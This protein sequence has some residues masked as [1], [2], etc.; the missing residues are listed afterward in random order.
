MRISSSNQQYYIPQ[1]QKQNQTASELQA[2]D[3][4][5]ISLA[6]SL[7]SVAAYS[8]DSD[9]SSSV[10]NI[11]SDMLND[12]KVQM[13]KQRIN[14]MRES[15]SNKIE[16]IKTT[17]DTV[18][19]ADLENMSLEDKQA[20][21]ASVDSALS[22][23]DASISEI[24]ALS[25]DE[26]TQILTDIQSQAQQMVRGPSGPSGPGG[27]GGPGRLGGPC[28]PGDVSSVEEDDE[29]KSTLQTLLD[30]LYAAD[31]DEEDTTTTSASNFLQNYAINQY[32]NASSTRMSSLLDVSE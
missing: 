6:N 24:E 1:T 8:S 17:M 5:S 25:E 21:L 15:E 19:E 2:Y 30:A 14:S 22:G 3:A 31:E 16:I 10:D 29:E 4:S 32:L 13:M 7:F 9:S 18:S 12:P 20:L 11:K 28:G 26:L 23:E 27:P